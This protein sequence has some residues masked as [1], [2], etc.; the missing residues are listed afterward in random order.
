M[1]IN[2]ERLKPQ[3]AQVF[4]RY[5]SFNF[6]RVLKWEPC[7]MRKWANYPALEVVDFIAT[8]SALKLAAMPG[9]MPWPISH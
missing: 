1:R 9:K 4:G 2:S 7:R 8:R 5:I 3:I 6:Y